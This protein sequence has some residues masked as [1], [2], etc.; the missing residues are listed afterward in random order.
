MAAEAQL[1]RKLEA[2]AE[3]L[4]SPSEWLASQVEELSAK[5]EAAPTP[6]AKK[7]VAEQLRGTQARLQ[8]IRE[9]M[10]AIASQYVALLEANPELATSQPEQPSAMRT[11]TGGSPNTK[12]RASCLSS[13]SFQESTGAMLP[14]GQLVTLDTKSELLGPLECILA[15]PFG[16]RLKPDE[17]VATGLMICL[18]GHS[19]S[20]EI[21]EEWAGVTRDARWLDLGVSVALPNLEMTSSLTV[22]DLEC[23]VEAI[24]DLVSL[25]TCILVG[26]AWGALRAVEV[27]AS[28]RLSGKVE[29]LIL[30]A[31]SSPA[32]ME[33]QDLDVPVLVVWAKDDDTES[34]DD[35]TAWMEALDGRCA[36][37][38]LQASPVG[39]HNFYKMLQNTD[40]LAAVRNFTVTCL[41]LAEMERTAVSTRSGEA[42]ARSRRLSSELPGFLEEVADKVGDGDDEQEEVKEDPAA[43]ESREVTAARSKAKRMSNILPQWIQAGMPTA[44]E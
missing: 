11:L 34:F 19:P 8:N 39:G 22:S 14:G 36:P 9:K 43:P 4:K 44:A 17:Y 38:T 6:E 28:E 32:P 41:L 30:V 42:T 20:P 10:D 16:K 33:A 13:Q 5:L 37:T 27:A 40:M 23:L 1:A 18:H 3:E 29:G 35:S 15:E 12:K 25:G 21:M 2:Q 31:P 24:L 26:K 7:A